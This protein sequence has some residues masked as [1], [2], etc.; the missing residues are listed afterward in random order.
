[1][2]GFF[3]ALARAA[4]DGNQRQGRVEAVQAF[5]VQTQLGER[6]RAKRG[7][8]HVGFGQFA[9]QRLL[10]GLGFQIRCQQ[11]DT[12][13]QLSVGGLA[14]AA[15]RVTARRLQLDATR[16]QLA[17]THQRGRAGQVESQAQ[18]ANALEGLQ[19]FGWGGAHLLFN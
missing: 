7:E 19:G 8:Q 12:F 6:R 10:A 15:H 13:V 17:T 16:A 5:P 14:V 11:L 3:G 1:M 18:D 4:D 2:A 9:L